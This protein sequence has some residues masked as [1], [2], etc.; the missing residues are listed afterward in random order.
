MC[1]CV[2]N[3]PSKPSVGSRSISWNYP[4]FDTIP[5]IR[6]AAIRYVMDKRAS[7]LNNAEKERVQPSLLKNQTIYFVLFHARQQ[8]SP[9]WMKHE[10]GEAGR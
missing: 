1:N 8:I 2:T 10:R 5:K 7:E 9:T 6:Y 4:T 3:D